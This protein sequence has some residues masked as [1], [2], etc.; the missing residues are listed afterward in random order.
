[1]DMTQGTNRVLIGVRHRGRVGAA[2]GSDQQKMVY[3]EEEDTTGVVKK[4]HHHFDR[5]SNY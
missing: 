4:Y 2:R 5:D 3:M 1:M